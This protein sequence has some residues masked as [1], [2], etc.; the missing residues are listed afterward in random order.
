LRI[1]LLWVQPKRFVLQDATSPRLQAAVNAASAGWIIKVKALTGA[2][3]NVFAGAAISGLHGTATNW[4]WIETD[5]NC[6]FA[7]L[8]ALA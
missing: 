1:R 4:I 2:T 3:Q 8:K 6:Q 5:Q 7:A